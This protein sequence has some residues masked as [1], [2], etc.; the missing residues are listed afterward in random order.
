MLTP[1]LARVSQPLDDV[2][3]VHEGFSDKKYS[4]GLEHC[5]F[6]ITTE[7]QV[8]LFRAGSREERDA[9][10]EN[11]KPIMQGY[12]LHALITQYGV[13]ICPPSAAALP[14]PPSFDCLREAAPSGSAHG[15]S[16]RPS[17]A[18]IKPF[19]TM[20]FVLKAS[21]L[22]CFKKPD[23][24]KVAMTSL[25]VSSVVVRTKEEAGMTDENISD[26]LDFL[27]YYG[28]DVHLIRCAH[29]EDRD[30]W[31][32]NLRLTPGTQTGRTSGYETPVGVGA[33][34]F[35]GR[36]GSLESHASPG[37]GRLKKGARVLSKKMG[38]AADLVDGAVHG[39]VK[40]GKGAVDMA[41][42]IAGGA[43]HLAGSAVGILSDGS[44]DEDSEFSEVGPGNVVPILEGGKKMV[45]P[46][47]GGDDTDS[48][49]P[50]LPLPDPMA[51]SKRQINPMT[52]MGLG[53]IDDDS[54]DDSDDGVPLPGAGVPVP[55][56]GR[57][58]GGVGPMSDSM[59][60]MDLGPAS[61]APSVGGSAS[62]MNGSYGGGGPDSSE[63]GAPPSETRPVVIVSHC[64]E[65]A[66]YRSCNGLLLHSRV[67]LACLPL[68]SAHSRRESK[69]DA[70][71]LEIPYEELEIDK[72]IGR[73]S[74]GEPNKL[75]SAVI[76]YDRAA[77]A[78]PLLC[79]TAGLCAG[80]VYKCH[81]RGTTIAVKVLTDQAMN[82]ETMAEFK[83]EVNMMNKVRHP[84]VVLLMGIC[85]TAPH[86]SIITEYLPRGSMYRLLHHTQVQLEYRRRLKMAI[87]ISKGMAY[88]HSAT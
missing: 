66:F 12:L 2:L 20:W 70:D 55:G 74:F 73:G 36:R 31:V 86:L 79:C 28:D 30:E 27:I 88:L 64:Q 18:Q 48:P 77:D 3:T 44:D 21:K 85:S 43:V 69:I 24:V 37:F 53:H 75:L 35:G 38:S 6:Q 83:T 42:G 81:W 65:P 78:D 82:E 63:I 57:A 14:S 72:K 68:V 40:M 67:M 58:G 22:H 76:H 56:G 54:S 15:L 47:A 26:D 13:R 9:W 10:I 25:T 80:E 16:Q 45:N 71:L 4:C 8:L 60:S 32:E 7:R 61:D 41:G 46:M 17:A 39:S 50:P 49:T 51:G 52:A 29:E 84:N 33:V 34:Q 11:L 1:S 5:E 19:K 87:D 23:D 62:S 59:Q